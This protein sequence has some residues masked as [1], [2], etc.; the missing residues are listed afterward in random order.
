MGTERGPEFYNGQKYMR[1]DIYDRYEPVYRQVADL[2]PPVKGCPRIVD[3]GCGVGYFAKMVQDR[4]Y[5]KYFGIDFSLNMVDKAE[6]QA[7]GFLFMLADLT[8]KSKQQL[9]AKDTLFVLVEVLE[10]ITK[11]LDILESIPSG[12]QVIFSVPSFDARSHVRR[13]KDVAQVKGR[14]SK[15]LKFK[16]EIVMPWKTVNK[17]FI[18]SCVKI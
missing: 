9:Y 5:K 16:R 15:Y 6:G 18:F 2:L 8:E 4:G 13:F 10:H 11:D 12:G 14:Y 17:V 7:P 3:L 1:P